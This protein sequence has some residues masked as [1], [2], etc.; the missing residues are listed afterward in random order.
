MHHVLELQ[1]IFILNDLDYMLALFGSS[2]SPS[3]IP[4]P[5]S[6]APS[7]SLFLHSHCFLAKSW[8]QKKLWFLSPLF[9]ACKL[10]SHIFSSNIYFV[11]NNQLKDKL[12]KF[13]SSFDF[14]Y[15]ASLT[16]LLYFTMPVYSFSQHLSLLLHHCSL[17]YEVW[18]HQ[19][20]EH[21]SPPSRW[22]DLLWPRARE[23]A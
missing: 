19:W 11:F 17:P 2:P 1:L 7:S 21:A 22:C 5:Q 4:K 10:P 9:T 8:L 18:C 12:A 23:Q 3:I 13:L 16:F 14:L 15:I 6:N 20:E